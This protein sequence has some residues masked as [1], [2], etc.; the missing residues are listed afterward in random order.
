MPEK[1]DHPGIPRISGMKKLVPGRWGPPPLSLCPSLPGQAA[2]CD[3]R[4]WASWPAL[5]PAGREASP[6]LLDLLRHAVRHPH[7]DTYL[8]SCFSPYYCV[9]FL[10]LLKREDQLHRSIFKRIGRKHTARKCM[11]LSLV[12]MCD[13]GEINYFFGICCAIKRSHLK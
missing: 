1:S 13:S 2:P 5:R 11:H 6:A 8:R 4:S 7:C 12:K 10:V 9:R 3:S